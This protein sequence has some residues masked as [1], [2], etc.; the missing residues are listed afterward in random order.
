MT[1][2]R[3]FTKGVYARLLGLL[4]LLFPYAEAQAKVWEIPASDRLEY[5]AQEALLLAEPGDTVLLPAGRFEMSTELTM[6]RPF[7]TLKGRG[8][9][10]TVLVY[11]ENAVGPQAIVASADHSTVEDLTIVDHPGDGVKMVGIRGATMRRL[12]VEWSRRG[13]ADNGAYGLYPVLST[14][15]LIEDCIVIGA[16]DAGIYVG[17]SHQIVVRRNRV[18]YNVAGIEIE[19]SQRADVYQNY[20]TNNTGGILIFNLPNLLVQGGRGTRL[21]NNVLFKNNFKNFAPPGNSVAG[22]P[23]G[24]G[25]LVLANDD[26]EIFSNTIENHNTT[27]IAIVSFYALERPID[28]PSFDAIPENIYIHGNKL[29]NAGRWP[30]QGANELGIA[31]AALSFPHRIPHIT[32]DGIGL[33]D[34]EGNAYPA[35]LEGLKRICIGANDQDGGDKSYWGNLQLWKS[36]WWSPV[37]GELDRSLADYSC[38]LPR[39]D[40]VTLATPPPPPALEPGPDASEIAA[41]CTSEGEGVN[42]QALA[43]DCPRLSDYRLFSQVDDPLSQPQETGFAYDLT[44]PLFS[45]YASKGRVVFIPPGSSATYDAHATFD[46]PVGSVVAKTFYFP[47][48]ERNPD[49]PRRTIETRLLI[50]RDKGWAGLNYIWKQGEA[51]LLRGGTVVPVAWTDAQGKARKND[52]QVPNLAQ[53]SGCHLDMVPLGLKA[54]YLNKEGKGEFA[55]SNQLEALVAQGL[56]SEAPA[57]AQQMTRYP[58]WNKPSSGSLA[59]RA[60]AYLD[61]NCAHCHSLSGKANTSG[62][63]LNFAQPLNITYGLCKPPIAAGRGAG[64]TLFDIVPGKPQDSILVSRMASTKAAIKM[65]ELAKSMAHKEGVE[66]VSQWIRSLEGECQE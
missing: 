56:L 12:K 47:L 21:F 60:R 9:D 40:R 48:D 5:E 18:E 58:I 33:V 43:V 26:I 23:Q 25:V 17:Q 31:A 63:F 62:L 7:V 13:A 11:G 36:K 15:V 14:D 64:G 35:Q 1:P 20:A 2:P 59:Q 54:G 16:S 30:L 51:T 28:D 24:T 66:L 55:G 22:I 49:G 45:D 44:T 52:Y 50:H 41:L 61:I 57:T 65:P 46:L 8:I 10:R 4:I 42:W 3:V 34:A 37:P 39:L 29:R 19:N 38:E 32:Y 27:S 53:C 6:S